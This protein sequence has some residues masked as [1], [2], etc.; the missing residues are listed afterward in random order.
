MKAIR[1]VKK[2][3]TGFPVVVFVLALLVSFARVALADDSVPPMDFLTQVL[4]AIKE[5]G[6]MS[7]MAKVSTIT[8]LLVAS[9]KVSFLN[10]LL[11]NKLGA[12]KAW[13]APILGLVA[14]ILSVLIS[15]GSL[16]TVFAY[17]TAGAGAIILHELLDTI[18]ATPGIGPIVIGIIEI[19][20]KFLGNGVQTL[21]QDLSKKDA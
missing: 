15:G 9:M 2:L 16:A 3:W 7:W 18:K 6:G 11:W 10:D 5:L 4:N 17:V 13:A 21:P 12:F 8:L 19:I 1:H 14:G 20:E